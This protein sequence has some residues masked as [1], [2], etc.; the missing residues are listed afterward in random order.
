[1]ETATSYSM[2]V[3]VCVCMCMWE[4]HKR[5]I[6]TGTHTVLLNSKKKFKKNPKQIPL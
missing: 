6:F 3:F 1:M 2:C 5:N 4:Q